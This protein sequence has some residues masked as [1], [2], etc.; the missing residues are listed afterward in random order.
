MARFS[1][2]ETS[3]Y[4]STPDLKVYAKLSQ[5]TR[6]VFGRFVKYFVTDLI[7]KMLI[8]SQETPLISFV[9]TVLFEAPVTRY[10][11]LF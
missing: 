11:V 1:V 2:M 5:S 10:M 4:V 8:N 3:G 7:R 6:P 9:S